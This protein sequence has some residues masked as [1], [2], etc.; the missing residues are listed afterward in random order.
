MTMIMSLHWAP[1]LIWIHHSSEATYFISVSH[2]SQRMCVCVWVYVCEEILKFDVYARYIIELRLQIYMP[3]NVHLTWFFSHL[4][5]FVSTDIDAA[6]SRDC[7]IFIRTNKHREK[8]NTW[9]SYFFELFYKMKSFNRVSWLSN[10][11][12]FAIKILIIAKRY[13]E[14]QCRIFARSSNAY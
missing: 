9:N 11:S 12:K 1:R 8:F 10:L 5:S 4:S 2:V 3:L 7:Q 13:G 6:F 14:Y